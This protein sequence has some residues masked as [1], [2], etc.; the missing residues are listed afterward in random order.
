MIA[1]PFVFVP[2]IQGFPAGLL[3]Y[4]ITTNLWTVGQQYVIRRGAGLPVLGAPGS[5]PDVKPA[6]AAAAVADKGD[7]AG[8]KPAKEPKAKAKPSTNGDDGAA[9]AERERRETAPPPPPRQRRKKKHRD[10]ADEPRTSSR[11]RVAGAARARSST[12]LGLEGRRRGR[13]R[14]RRSSPARST[15]TISGLFIGRH[16]QTIDAVQHL[17]YR[18]VLTRGGGSPAATAGRRRRRGLPRAPRRG[19]AAPGRPGGRGGACAR[20]P[21]RAR[22]DDGERAQARARVP[23][24]SRRRRDVQRGRGARSPPRRGPAGHRLE[25]WNASAFHVKRRPPPSPR[26]R[27]HV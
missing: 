16:G 12:A 19:A 22:R 20:A 21:G 17:A 3:V 15:A 4:W 2:F 5:G 18:I 23:A 10:G 11:A 13:P 8:P 6:G 27:F 24:R 14:R 25:A 26:R 9:P 7:R 1:L